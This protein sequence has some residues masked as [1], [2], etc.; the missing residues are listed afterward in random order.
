MRLLLVVGLLIFVRVL[1]QEDL[2]VSGTIGNYSGTTLELR[3]VAYTLDY[4]PVTLDQTTVGANGSFSLEL[5]P[6]PSE[7]FDTY[8]GLF[9]TDQCSV[10][11]S[12]E[13][14]QIAGASLSYRQD[15]TAVGSLLLA[16]SENVFSLF[17]GDLSNAT[18]IDKLA[19]P[20]YATAKSTITGLCK[21]T[22]TDPALTSVA[23][24]LEPGWNIVVLSFVQSQGKTGLLMTTGSSDGLNWYLPTY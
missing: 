18:K 24:T 5:S 3:A 11:V 2:T 19:A 20:L 7:T 23:I 13:T 9:P 22:D 1:A 14:V 10:S 16:S 4:Q 12:E 21:F 15:G 6:P 8:T 17:T